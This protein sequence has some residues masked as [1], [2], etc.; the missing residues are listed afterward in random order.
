MSLRKR[1]Y[2]ARGIHKMSLKH[3]A[4][5]PVKEVLKNSAESERTQESTVA[6]SGQKMGWVEQKK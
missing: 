6:L 3:F 5:I 2:R 1:F 4:R